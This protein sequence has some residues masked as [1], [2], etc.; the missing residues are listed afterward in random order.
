MPNHSDVT[1][2]WE[3]ERKFLVGTMPFD[4]EHYAH[5]RIRQGYL[6]YTDDGTEVR[7]RHKGDRFFQTV[8]RGIGL[9]RIE[10]ELALSREQFEALWPLTEGKRL[11]KVRYAIPYDD[12]T[13]EVDVY[14][15]AL[16][17]LKTAEVEFASVER[18]EGFQPPSWFEREITGEAGYRNRSLAMHGLPEDE[19]HGRR[20]NGNE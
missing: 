12:L 17:G 19:A 20:A 14:L 11:E 2:I 7:V 3:I 6:A 4:L 16:E 5:E 10:V 18:S 15:G 13:I 9:R 1:S 8:K